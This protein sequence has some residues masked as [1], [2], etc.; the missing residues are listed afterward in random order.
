MDDKVYELFKERL[1]RIE[2]KVDRLIS[3][4]SYVLGIA[5]VFGFIGSFVHSWWRGY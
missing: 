5:S 2:I 3:F 1:D 4:R